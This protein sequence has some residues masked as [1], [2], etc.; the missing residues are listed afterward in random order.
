MAEDE[1][2]Q[3]PEEEEVDPE[4]QD[5]EDDDGDEDDDEE[6]EDDGEVDENGMNAFE[7][8]LFAIEEEKLKLQL[9]KIK[10][11]M[12]T[13]QSPFL[14][15]RDQTALKK[16]KAHKGLKLQVKAIEMLRAENVS[17]KT[18]KI[19]SA[20]APAIPWIC[21]GALIL[22]LAIAI[23][24]FI[25]S[26]FSW[27]DTSSSGGRPAA[28]SQFGVSGK[29][30]YGVRT[31]YADEK[32]SRAG[33][34][35]EYVDLFTNAMTQVTSI[36]SVESGGENVSVSITLN[37]TLPEEYNYEEFDETQFSTDYGVLY[38]KVKEVAQI[39]Y[40]SDNGASADS[41][42][43]LENLV[44]G[45][46]YFGFSENLLDEV[47]PKVKELI[48]NSYAF[49]GSAQSA[50]V[51]TAVEEKIDDHFS[52]LSTTRAEKVFIKDFLFEKVD[53]RMKDIYEQGYIAAIFMPKKNVTITSIGI[54]ISKVNFDNF[55]IKL[56]GEEGFVKDDDN[57][58]A[59][60]E[61]E[62]IFLFQTGDVSLN[63]TTFENIDL[64]NK[65]ELKNGVS[66]AKLMVSSADY[67]KYLEVT[68]N[69]SGDEYYTWKKDG[70]I[71]NFE[72]DEEFIFVEYE[73][74]WN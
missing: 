34:I 27:M 14:S 43:T 55:S 64:A 10:T 17:I 18:T 69:E 21:L 52:S 56:N 67:Q 48:M 26:L 49:T 22:F 36:T 35:E 65:N 51:A 58:K 46:K 70:I 31:I 23:V 73:T 5:E 50:D 63:A 29:D 7:R 66:L 39:V 33:L 1:E 74:K 71:I 47:K 28:N 25:V 53:D 32:L 41:A 60:E 11:R 2:E 4:A 54:I 19:F 13:T 59:N 15:T 37:L 24:A 72:A 61:D 3:K 20:I 30:F 42:L 44:D 62:D 12:Q 68:T 40:E 57:L 6:D 45:I 9:E 16:A 38:S 8:K